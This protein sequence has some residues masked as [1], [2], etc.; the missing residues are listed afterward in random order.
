MA[1]TL[2]KTMKK[3]ISALLIAAF[4]FALQAPVAT[5]AE[6][7][8]PYGTSTVDPAGPNEIILTIS[9]GGRKSEFDYPRLMKMKYQ[10]ISIYEPFIKK[11]QTFTVIPIQNFFTLVGISGSDM[12]VTRALNDYVYKNTAAQFIKAGALVAVKR[13]GKD[14]PY[15]QGGPIRIIYGDKSGWAKELDAW[16]WSISSIT[17][18]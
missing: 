13:S 6:T 11:R 5:A 3:L 1:N 9:K 8:N 17:V 18:K 16:N 15:D 7:T 2:E 14:I 12:V 4:A 10:T